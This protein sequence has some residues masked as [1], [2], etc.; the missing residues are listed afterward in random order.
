MSSWTAWA[1]SRSWLRRTKLSEV[2][3]RAGLLALG[4]IFLF[5]ACGKKETPAPTAEV[6]SQTEETAEPSTAAVEAPQRKKNLETILVM[7]LDKNEYP[8]DTRAYL[9]DMQGDFNL[10]L[11]LDK[12]T[13]ICTPLLLNRDTM[14]EITRLGVFGDE[15]DTFTGQLAL[16]HTYGSGGSD[17]C[18]NAKKAVSTL[19][20]DT[21][22][23]HYMSF[24][25]DSV[26][27]VNDA[28]GGVTLTV[29]DDF[30]GSDTLKK[31][32]TVTLKGED[33]LVYVRGR[34][35]AGDQTNLSRMKRQEQ[36]MSAMIDNLI[37]S[38]KAD[39]DFL[40]KLTFQL[41][42]S[43]QTDYS[44]SQLQ[45]L[46]DTLINAT[47]APFRTI[48]GEAK[49]GEEFMEFYVNETDLKKTVQELFYQ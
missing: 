9:N 43:F 25:M 3:L 29:L 15:V 23:D 34:K 12:D 39:P 45:K 19:L 5:S 4:A 8:S 44:V 49:L 6:P 37:A 26:P 21:P 20:E 14:T 28:I 2:A 35:G 1:P 38:A 16:A 11:V 33:A 36:Y 46:A 10:V 17:S 42:D 31:G 24:T 40:T 22:I 7:G 27:T 30:E 41:G 47:I 32:E 13:N 18:L 48:D